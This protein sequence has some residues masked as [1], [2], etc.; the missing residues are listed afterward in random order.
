VR[1]ATFNILHGAAAPTRETYRD[2]EQSGAADAAVRLSRSIALLDADILGLQEVDHLQA[3]SGGADLVAVAASA[4]GAHSQRFLPTLIGQ[5]GGRWRPA[6]S[7]EQLSDT[8]PDNA[9]YGIALLSRFPVSG[10]QVIR[11]PALHARV[12]FLSPQT[13]RPILIREE[14]RSALVAR[15]QAPGRSLTIAV[16]HLSFVPGWASLQLGVLRR[17]L[18][19][20]PDLILMGDLNMGPRSARRVTELEPLATAPTFPVQRPIRQLDHMLAAASLSDG[21]V[22]QALALPISDHRALVVDLS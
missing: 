17:A 13:L 12:P 18:G 10:W 22:A 9:S 5:P 1:I 21:V 6:S 20:D 8:A 3:R 7:P 2:S 16:T 11:L 15:I 19:A 14:P 4:M